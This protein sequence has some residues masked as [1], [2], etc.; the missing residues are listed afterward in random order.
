M[1]Q[2]LKRN[3]IFLFCSAFLILHFSNCIATSEPAL[4]FS[5]NTQHILSKSNGSLISSA[6]VLKKGES[7]SYAISLFYYNTTYRGPKNSVTEIAKDF[8]IEK[9]AVVDYATFSFLGP[10]F[11]KNCVVVWGE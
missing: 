2:V 4:L 7:C 9:I 6:R 3:R 11:Y 10:V 1:K 5:Y 8:G